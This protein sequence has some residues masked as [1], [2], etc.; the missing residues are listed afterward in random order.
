MDNFSSIINTKNIS[1]FSWTMAAW[2][3]EN[4]LFSVEAEDDD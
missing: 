4:E 2:L 3:E 1:S